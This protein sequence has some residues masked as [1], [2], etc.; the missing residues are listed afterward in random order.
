MCLGILAAESPD[1]QHGGR[2]SCD[3]DGHE[4]SEDQVFLPWG[5]G[6]PRSCNRGKHGRS[7]N[8]SERRE[9]PIEICAVESAPKGNG[10]RYRR[11]SYLWP[12]GAERNQ[13]RAIHDSFKVSRQP[14]A[15]VGE[16]ALSEAGQQ[17]DQKQEHPVPHESPIAIVHSVPFHR[18]R[19]LAEVSRCH[20]LNLREQMQKTRSSR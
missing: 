19:I 16:M 8:R 17:P 20:A 11:D 15:Y 14:H 1:K 7:K 18:D 12:C 6:V 5:P 4:S 3:A 9:N 13:K 2:D 10:F